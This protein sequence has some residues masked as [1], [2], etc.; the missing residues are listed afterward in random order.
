MKL[1]EIEKKYK[2]YLETQKQTPNKKEKEQVWSKIKDQVQQPKWENPIWY[3][4][5]AS[6]ALLLLSSFTIYQLHQKDQTISRLQSNLEVLKEHQT[7]LVNNNTQLKGELVTLMNRPPQVDTVIITNVVYRIPDEHIE[8]QL[9]INENENAEELPVM[10]DQEMP[11]L[12]NLQS[13]VESLEIEYGEKTGEGVT[14]WRFTVKY[15]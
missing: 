3:L 8:T 1:M 14:P 12:A 7:E 11:E 10:P 4:A 15:H 2:D 13:D 9:V 6:V 5:A